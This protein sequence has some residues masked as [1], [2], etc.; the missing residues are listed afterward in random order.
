MFEIGKSY[1]ITNRYK[2]SYV[3]E[4]YYEKD[5]VKIK[6][7]IGWRTGT[8]V[9]TIE[10]QE[11][12]EKLEKFTKEDYEGE[13]VPY[14]EFENAEFENSWDGCWEDW[15]VINGDL[16]IDE[17]MENHETNTEEDE[18]YEFFS[19]DEFLEDG[20]GFEITDDKSYFSGSLTVE[21]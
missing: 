9:I 15:E 13:I 21:E 8:W 7:E 12:A 5:D 10:N 4:T 14:E 11:E 6:R 17:M 16:A 2:K 3:E 20:E 1:T 19:F 18:D